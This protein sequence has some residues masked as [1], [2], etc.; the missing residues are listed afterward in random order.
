MLKSVTA[1]FKMKLFFEINYPRFTQL[2]REYWVL[3]FDS[4][5]GLGIFLFTTASRTAQGPTQPPI[6]WVPGVLSR[7]VKRSGREAD[8]TPPSSGEIKE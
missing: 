1:S 2:K 3:R 4:P 5:R 8:H 6:Q 7:G